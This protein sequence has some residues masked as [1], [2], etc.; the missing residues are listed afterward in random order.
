MCI[1][2][3]HCNTEPVAQV[4]LYVFDDLSGAAPEKLKNLYDTD[5][6]VK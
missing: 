4:L 6:T 2:D 5:Y 1:R 3:S